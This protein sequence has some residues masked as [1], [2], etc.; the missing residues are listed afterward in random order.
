MKFWQHTARIKCDTFSFLAENVVFR[1]KPTEGIY[2]RTENILFKR[3]AARKQK[4]FKVRRGV[5]LEYSNSKRGLRCFSYRLDLFNK[6]GRIYGKKINES[7]K[8]SPCFP[9]RKS[10]S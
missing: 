3:P 5:A 1:D 6:L 10:G 8:K 7:A 9:A 4:S 2:F